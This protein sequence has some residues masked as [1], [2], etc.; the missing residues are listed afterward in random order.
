MNQS[1][2]V[3]LGIT[4]VAIIGLI[5]LVARF[6]VHAFIA[7]ILASLFVGTCAVHPAIRANSPLRDSPRPLMAV[8]SAFQDGVG[9]TLAIVAVVVG[10]GTMLG[11][12]LAESGGA[13]VV[14]TRFI[15]VFGPNRL[16]WALLLVAFVV[17]LP[18]FFAVGLVLLVP[19]LFT[20]ARETRLPL[21]YLGLPLVA[22]LSAS[23]SLVPPHP[24]P[25]FAVRALEADMGK[26]IFYSILAGLPAAVLAGPV[27][28]AFV[29]KRFP[30]ELG[31]IGAQ[32]SLPSAQKRCPSFGIALL[33]ILLPVL[34]M[35][36]ATLAD[37]T[38]NEKHQVRIW[39]DFLGTPLVAM[40]A[41]VIVAL[42]TFGYS[43]GFDRNQ[44][45]KFTEDC[46]GPAASIMLI[47]GA[48]GGFSK[49]LQAVGAADAIS[50]G[51]KTMGVPPMIFG[52][53][54]AAAIRLATGSA[55]VSISLAAGIMTPVAVANS[56]INRE[57][58]IVAMGAGSMILS[59]VN[60]GGFWFVKEYLNMTVAQTLK[61]W[62]VM[63]TIISIVA[64]VLVLLLDLIV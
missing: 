31:G 41:A 21:V 29:G 22:G 63:V 49:V 32:L 38:L 58:L 6:K 44:I 61:T 8:A 12:M 19:I 50:A 5:V 48:G 53:L 40:L 57:L 7:L 54:V 16:P 62:S 2:A 23:H 20:L 64:L 36:L 13:E 35:L 3:L 47:V 33:T 11:K 34:L 10:L 59:H 18:V 28:T 55:T 26:T 14:A 17:G 30:V 60:D 52:W 42:F 1:H 45:L 9:N 4:L 15:Q 25:T 39:A 43:C 37:L 46:L 56:S 27:F 51:V 24:G